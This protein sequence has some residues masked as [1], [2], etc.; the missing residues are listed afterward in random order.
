MIIVAITELVTS[1]DEETPS[2]ARETGLAPYEARL[3]L[4]QTPPIIAMRT[5]DRDAA[6]RLLASLRSRKHDAVACDDEAVPEPIPVRA[7]GELPDPPQILAVVR[8]V[9]TLRNESTKSVTERKLRPGMAL[10]T[11]GLVMSKKVTREEKSV[12]LD[13]EELLYVFLREGGPPRIVTE[14]GTSYATLPNAA[15]TQ[16]ENFLR[17]AGDLQKKVPIWDERLVALRNVED[18]REI[19]LRAQLVAI[20]IARRQKT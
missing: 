9:R 14:R 13:R 7:L 6:L 5:P 20:S 1:I 17:V 8:A 3:R 16:R 2:F 18:P 19:D 15:P 10:A 4:S 11:G 12:A